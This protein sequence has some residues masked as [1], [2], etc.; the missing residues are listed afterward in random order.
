MFEYNSLRDIAESMGTNLM[1]YSSIRYDTKI[2]IAIDL[3]V[4]FGSNELTVIMNVDWNT[5][6]VKEVIDFGE[7]TNNP[8]KAIR[9]L[10]N[11]FHKYLEMWYG[12]S[13]WNC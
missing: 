10:N 4:I 2:F 8:R 13:Y 1:D 5:R 6:K 7:L 9:S 12:N 3:F 11:S